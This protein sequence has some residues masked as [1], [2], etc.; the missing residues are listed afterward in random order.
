V[1]NA[2]PGKEALLTFA[3]QPPW[4][5]TKLA[6][7]IYVTVT[8]SLIVFGAW[9]FSYL[10]RREMNR[11]GR[12]IA[13]RT[14]ALATSEERYRGL[15]AKLEARVSERTTE[16]SKSNADLK[17]EIAE[18]QQAEERARHLAAFPELNPNPV[19][20]FTADGI[21]AYANLAAHALADAAG[22]SD[23][24]ALLPPGTR[25]IV[26]EC[27][28]Q[29]QSRLRL[30]TQ[31]GSRTISWSFYPIASQGTVHCYAGDITERL[32]LEERFRQAQKMEA[33]G[34]L[35]GGV[36]HDFNNLLTVIQGHCELL[37]VGATAADA[38]MTE[39]A[40]EIQAAAIRAANLTRQLL[41]FS[42]RQPMQM[43]RLDLNEVVSSVSRM[44]KRLIGEDI[45]LHTRLLPDGAW[46]EGDAGM[47]EQVLLNLAV[48]ARDAMRG[49]GDLWLEID[50]VTLDESAARRHPAA[51]SGTFVCL[52]MRDTGH[53]IA[54]DLLPHIFEPFFTTKEV[55]KGTGL[56]LATVHGIVEQHRGWVEVESPPGR[57]TTFRVHLPRLPQGAAQPESP[58]DPT[59]THGGH[60]AILVVEDEPAVRA[61]AVKILGAQGYRVQ[62][63]A[64]GAAAL[65]L[66]Q[67]HAGAFDL[68]L[69]D[70]VMPGGVS[71]AQLAERLRGEQPG[72]RVIYMSGYCAGM[73]TAAVDANFLQKPFDPTHLAK[74]I[75]SCLD[76]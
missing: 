73:T 39:S 20:E 13:Q 4:Y 48:N 22:V 74:A 60:E 52:S 2:T 31:S 8:V 46:I 71:G 65:E 28:A 36:A 21:L 45:V 43:R 69:T 29:G 37:L 19:F 50:E 24:S 5:R 23:P 34:Q 32:Q 44:L 26:A 68:L 42:R 11:L 66:W 40:K 61:L 17:R 57:G 75:R 63:A 27:L 41:T 55:G 30:E 7:A 49:G 35:A 16:L 6:W 18:R 3:V 64:T 53:G 59:R 58:R 67:R 47:I 72:L 62:A 54:A 33:I 38:E 70:L 51:R 76:A 14:S 1:L 25:Q 10:E 9:F 56:G 12:L 15:N